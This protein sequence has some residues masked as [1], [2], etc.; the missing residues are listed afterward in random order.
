[1]KKNLLLIILIIV[2]IS[3]FMFLRSKNSKQS[4]VSIDIYG[5]VKEF[6]INGSSFK[7]DPSTISV[8]KGDEVRITFKNIDGNH[9]LIIDGYEVSSKILSSGRED[10]FEFIADKLGNFQFYCSLPGHKTQGM[11]GTL[12]VK[13]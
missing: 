6:T 5:P 12:I 4:N 3:T 7:Y 11:V 10:T 2:V 9:N 13:I 1:M 8:N